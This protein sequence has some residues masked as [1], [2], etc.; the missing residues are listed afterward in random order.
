MNASETVWIDA[1]AVSDL[2]EDRPTAVTIGETPVVLI[3]DEEAVYA[4][5]GKC[6]H[7]G[8]PMEQ[9]TLCRDAEGVQ[10]LV[11]PWHKAVF[12]AEGGHLIDPPAQD[13]LPRYPV[14]LRDGR[15]FVREAQ[16]V[17]EAR[18]P[19]RGN[20]IV[21]I[22]G[23]G[24]AGVTA[25]ATLRHLGFAGKIVMVG[26]EKGNP[27][28]RTA[29]SKAYLAEPKE[30]ASLP[31]ILPEAFYTRHDIERVLD[32]VEKVDHE[33][34][35]VRLRSGDSFQADHILC[36]TGS[37]AV[38]PELPGVDLPNVF[39]LR[40]A[41][42][43]EALS[44]AIGPDTSIAIVG[45]GLIALEA[46]ASLRK[47]G[48]G[49]T[50]ISR[51]DVPLIGQFGRE[52]GCRLRE[53]HEGNGVAFV[54]CTE[55]KAISQQGNALKLALDD[56]T[57]LKTDIVLLGVGAEPVVHYADVGVRA[58]DGGIEVD[59]HMRVAGRVYA[60][61]DIASFVHEGRRMRVEHWRTAECQARIAV[62]AMLGFP[63]SSL[64]VPWFWT[65]QYDQKLE[66]A[67]WS[68]S[69]DEVAID[70]D[71]SAFDFLARLRKDGKTVGF[72]GSKHAREMGR[73]AVDF[74]AA[75]EGA[76]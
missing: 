60:A 41:A 64:P 74:P 34:R 15:V 65:Q 55:V 8:A 22:L 39:T 40:S 72:I 59:D 4:L 35:T 52:V 70:G 5:G 54:P 19:M 58:D 36:A 51:E 3:R 67:G 31:D 12:D 69:F 66:Y 37:R 11:C 63:I 30:E 46:A 1:G 76:A 50:V 61:G 57:E 17:P 45:G 10:V 25:A 29:L 43:A 44:D 26:P 33:T 49:V 14:E 53:L 2:A 28:E 24:A 18:E 38:R 13:C 68:P 6:P 62:H 75:C 71:L 32:S 47:R 42:D 7:R 16:I 73:I 27:Y 20:E 23:V 48:A 56:E 9:G 21:A